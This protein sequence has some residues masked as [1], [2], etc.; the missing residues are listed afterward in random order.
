[1]FDRISEE[2][3]NCIQRREKEKGKERVVVKK[4]KKRMRRNRRNVVRKRGNGEGRRE[5]KTG[6]VGVT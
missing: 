5:N 3:R 2:R 1:M 4:E 6:K